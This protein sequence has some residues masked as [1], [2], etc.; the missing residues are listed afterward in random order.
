MAT[1][2]TPAA[3][4]ESAVIHDTLASGALRVVQGCRLVYRKIDGN[5]VIYH[6]LQKV[7]AA[8]DDEFSQKLIERLIVD[9][10][11]WMPPRLYKA[12]PILLPFTLRDPSCRSSGAGGADEWGSANSDGY[13]RDDNSLL[14]AVAPSL[15]IVSP[16]FPSYEGGRATKGFV[17]SHV[18]RQVDV[19]GTQCLASRH[20]RLYSF[21][22]NF[23]WL[24]VQISKLTDREKSHAQKAMQALSHTIY[25]PHR[26]NDPPEIEAL[27]GALPSPALRLS[28]RPK[29][30]NYFAVTDKWLARRRRDMSR[31]VS[32][33]LS[34]LDGSD[35]GVTKIKCSRYLP[36]LRESLAHQS[37]LGPWLRRYADIAG[38]DAR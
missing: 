5:H 14:K 29:Q 38:L 2:T 32:A 33:I 7:V 26:P 16:R 20:P 12:L 17:A 11:V 4:H 6:Y 25:G 35:P 13:L 15:A 22:P 30:L 36:S 19:G 23:A 24:P 10:S 37:D 21:V 31:E 9:L 8:E 1:T 18:W 28:V 34:V 27:W 3:G